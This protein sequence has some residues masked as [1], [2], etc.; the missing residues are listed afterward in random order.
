MLNYLLFYLSKNGNRA[1]R[2][3]SVAWSSKSSISNG[4]H[5]PPGNLINTALTEA[6]RNYL[7]QGL[8]SKERSSLWNDE[9]FWE[10]MFLDAVS[11]ERDISG[12]DQGA[13]EMIER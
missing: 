8:I 12:L 9:Q 6:K 5:Y 4:M 10:D 13:G 11:Q 7:F 1:H 2:A 3:P